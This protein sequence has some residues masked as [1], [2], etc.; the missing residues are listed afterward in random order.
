MH[1][2]SLAPKCLSRSFLSLLFSR[3]GRCLTNSLHEPPAMLNGNHWKYHL[4]AQAHKPYLPSP[5]L[6]TSPPPPHKAQSFERI[7]S[8]AQNK[9]ETTTDNRV[10]HK[11]FDSLNSSLLSVLAYASDIW[12]SKRSFLKTFPFQAEL[13]GRLSR[14][15]RGFKSFSWRGRKTAPNTRSESYELLISFVYS[16]EARDAT[17]AEPSRF[18]VLLFSRFQRFL[19]MLILWYFQFICYLAILKVSICLHHPDK[20]PCPNSKSSETHQHGK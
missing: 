3:D 15:A 14:D 2:T 12:L 8:E 4:L 7:S 16:T 18:H 17:R 1:I 6:Q 10:H 13:K 5:P 11:T 9:T 19:K 20:L